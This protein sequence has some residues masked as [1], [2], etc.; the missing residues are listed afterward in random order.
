MISENLKGFIIVFS[1][2]SLS[3]KGFLYKFVTGS[4]S[5]LSIS[6]KKTGTLEIVKIKAL[7][8]EKSRIFLRKLTNNKYIVLVF[9]NDLFF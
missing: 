9:R 8:L 5:V 6:F 3:L 4:L 2:T 7:K 1:L